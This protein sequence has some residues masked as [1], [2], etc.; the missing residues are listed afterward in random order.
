MTLGV[1][2]NAVFDIHYPACN[3]VAIL[4]HVNYQKELISKLEAVKVKHLD[5]YSP[6]AATSITD[7]KYNTLSNEEKETLAKQKHNERVVRAL[8]YIRQHV[9]RSIAN[10]F[11]KE[12]VITQEQFE[13]FEQV[14]KN[15][16]KE[17]N[18][19]NISVAAASFETIETN[20]GENSQ[21]PIT[22]TVT[23]YDSQ[24]QPQTNNVNTL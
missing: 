11:C 16:Y 4:T 21:S 12:G 14:L 1:F 23:D 2:N 9:A 18:H 7:P 13:S 3:V 10:Y 5:T 19:R 24:P 20:L 15:K 6:I 8:P 17:Q 22:I